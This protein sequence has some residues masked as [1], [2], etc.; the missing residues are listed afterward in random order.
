LH[1]HYL[2]GNYVHPK[3]A[4][5]SSLKTSKHSAISTVLRLK[6]AASSW[7]FVS[8]GGGINHSGVVSTE[9]VSSSMISVDL[10]TSFVVNDTTLIMSNMVMVSRLKR[11]HEPSVPDLVGSGF[12]RRFSIAF[13]A[14]TFSCTGIIVSSTNVL[15]S[16]GTVV[17]SSH[18]LLSTNPLM[19]LTLLLAAS[20]RAWD[21]FSLALLNPARYQTL[22]L[23]NRLRNRPPRSR[24]FFTNDRTSLVFS[25]RQV[26]VAKRDSV[27]ATRTRS[28]SFPTCRKATSPRPHRTSCSDGTQI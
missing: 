11:L 28:R 5:E 6:F 18:I 22:L 27:C 26:V 3:S 10:V 23:G 4:H 25:C 12:G 7:K 1:V 13:K 20:R 16:L 19:H 2:S 14:L 15:S 9:A 8:R 21:T 24:T 17:M